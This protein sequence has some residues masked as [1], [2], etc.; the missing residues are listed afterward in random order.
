MNFAVCGADI[1]TPRRCPI[2]AQP[3]P[4]WWIEGEEVLAIFGLIPSES[5]K[6]DYF[7]RAEI[8]GVLDEFD[9]FCER[10]IKE[11]SSAVL[12]DLKGEE[13]AKNC[14]RVSPI[15][16]VDCCDVEVC[17]SFCGLC[18]DS[19]SGTGINDVSNKRF[20]LQDRSCGPLG[21]FIML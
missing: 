3:N 17:L 7:F 11:E 21:S 13:I 12:S 1:M 14:S 10:G 18:Q 4:V 20:D 8:K 9:C 5:L 6:A 19:R 16:D 15:V 2:A